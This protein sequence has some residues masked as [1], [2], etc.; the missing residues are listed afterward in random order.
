V[1]SLKEGGGELPL[2]EIAGVLPQGVRDPLVMGLSDTEPHTDMPII[3]RFAA[4]KA[5]T[6]ASPLKSG[7]LHGAHNCSPIR[8][9][10]VSVAAVVVSTAAERETWC[11]ADHDQICASFLGCV[12]L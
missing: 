7:T 3:D 2:S 4:A 12:S 11:G 1:L 5:D 10:N 8:S 6:S 9:Q